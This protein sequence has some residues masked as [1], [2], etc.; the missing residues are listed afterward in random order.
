MRFLVLALV[1]ICLEG[2]LAAVLPADSLLDAAQSGDLA[3]VRRLVTESDTPAVNAR[4]T[5]SRTPLIFAASYGDPAIVQELVAAGA[6]VNSQDVHGW[7]PLHWAADTGHAAV[8]AE[9]LQDAADPDLQDVEGW[10]A[11]HWA[12]YRG[13]MDIVR[14]LVT[15][16]QANIN[17]HT[18]V[19]RNTR[20]SYSAWDLATM[21]GHRNVADY[22]HDLN[23]AD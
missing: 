18:Q 14:E 2:G 19:D 13:D 22:L 11:L 6:E 17:L 3:R 7:S 15:T 5:M 23:M 4:D 8:I 9:L 21:Y 16:G 12:A 20:K 1:M 10:T